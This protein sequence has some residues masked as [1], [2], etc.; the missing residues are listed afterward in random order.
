MVAIVSFPIAPEVFPVQMGYLFPL[1]VFSRS[2]LNRVGEPSTDYLCGN[3]YFDLT[4]AL[5]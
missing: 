5:V 1:S 4:D 3:C 2:V